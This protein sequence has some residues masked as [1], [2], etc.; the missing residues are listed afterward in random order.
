MGATS[1]ATGTAEAGGAGAAAGAGGRWERRLG[2]RGRGWGPWGL[3]LG[4]LGGRCQFW[5]LLVERRVEDASCDVGYKDFGGRVD[6]R[7]GLPVAAGEPG[8]GAWIW[9]SA[10][11][12]TWAETAR[13]RIM[14]AMEARILTCCCGGELCVFCFVEVLRFH[15]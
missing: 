10:I 8:P 15:V 12:E 13:G 2:P 6:V 11:C 7:V 5:S 4:L 3:P 9:P 14:K 1:G